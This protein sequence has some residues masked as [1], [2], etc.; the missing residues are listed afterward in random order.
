MTDTHLQPLLARLSLAQKVRLL[1][2][3][4]SWSTQPEPSIGLRRIVL[5]DGP[6]GVRGEVWDERDPSL[7]LPS[8]TALAATWDLDLAYRYGAVLASEARRKG[9]DVVL[10]PTINL[11]RSPLGGRH[12][13]AFSEDPL[14]TARLAA[15]YTRGLQEH[16][17]ATTLKHYVA[18]DFETDRFTV[19][20]QVDERTLRELYLTAFEE[21]VT[22]AHAWL[23]MSAYNAVNGATMTENPLLETPLCTD[24]GFDGVVV[25]DWTA[26]RSTEASARAR[27]DLVMPGPNAYWGAALV[28]AVQDGRV[29]EAAIDQ[30]VMR[31]LRLAERVGALDDFAAGRTETALNADVVAFAREVCAAGMVLVRN[32][33]ELPWPASGPRS[34]AL[35]GEPAGLPRTQGGGSATVVPEHVVSPLEGLRAALTD[36]AVTWTR[37]VRVQS[38]ITPLPPESIV[39]PESGSAGIRCRFFDTHDNVLLDERRVAAHLVWL[40]NAPADTVRVELSTRFRPTATG[41][42]RMGVACVGTVRM[43]IDDTTLFATDLEGSSTNLGAALFEP[44]TVSERVELETER[45]V[46]LRISYLVPPLEVSRRTVSIAIGTEPEGRS[47]EADIAEAVAAARAAEVAV[48]VVG[49]SPQVESEGFD[50]T[51]LALPGEQDAL[52]RAVAAANPRTVV[53]V[54]AGS[55]VLLPWCDMVSA[56]VL[57]WFGGQEFGHA[58]A[59]VLLGRVEPGGRLPTTWP[60]AEHDVPVLSTTPVKGKMRYAEGLHIGYRAWLKRHATPMFP[61]GF[62]LGYT[63]WELASLHVET[64]TGDG[65]VVARVTVRNGGSRAG[66]QVVQ[67]YLSRPGS[68]IDRPVRWLAGFA[69]VNAEPGAEQLVTLT[70]RRRAFAHWAGGWLVEPGTFVL[71]VGT[72]VEDLPLRADVELR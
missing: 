4:D 11:H 57:T 9:V 45:D 20:V 53:V 50:R 19:D 3:A 61:F 29:S 44:P 17:V 1:T 39:D 18:N 27:Q 36:A 55:P 41:A 47:T 30:K 32:T 16:G 48:V 52:V 42:V 68:A 56:I 46:Y 43:A 14:L 25:S 13:E 71:E 72:S 33:G 62:G 35:I 24:W 60:A 10:G 31:V 40:G 37:G 58:L 65:D 2:G 28:Q 23:V 21:A 49:T 8:A 22:D 59:D 6:S 64:P 34:V 5:S 15:A 38:G 26:V 69:T 70:L 12:F 63:D 66:R 51:S 7:N 54:N 67:A